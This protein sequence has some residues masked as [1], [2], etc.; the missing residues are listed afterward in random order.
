M[1]VKAHLTNKRDVI[2]SRKY[3]VID[4]KYAVIDR[5]YVTSR[6]NAI[7]SRKSK[8]LRYRKNRSYTVTDDVV[9]F[10]LWV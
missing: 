4:R 7:T 8:R 2:I 6:K 3:V 1:G 5:R 10:C 9:F